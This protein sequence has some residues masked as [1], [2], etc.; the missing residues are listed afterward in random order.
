MLVDI[1]YHIIT[2]IA[3]FITLTI[4]ILIGSTIIGSDTIIEKQ[5][6]LINDLE[7][8]FKTL[9]QE[10]KKF[11][12]Q[13]DQLEDRLATNLKLEK[14]IIP[15]VINEKLTGEKLLIISGDNVEAKI[16]NKL[17][18]LL[19]LANPKLIN[20]LKEDTTEQNEYT[21][22][23]LIGEVKED[24]ISDYS[25]SETEIVHSSVTNLD[26]LPKI[27]EFVLKLTT[28]KSKIREGVNID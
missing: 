16:E 17:I 7:N 24:L 1:K 27:I 18:N 6:N 22:L 19:E 28:K 9:R 14:K 3:L 13:V 4:G 11:A 26:S 5:Q 21:K 12:S 10:N 23:L 2:I 8:D 15:L 25:D 20:Q